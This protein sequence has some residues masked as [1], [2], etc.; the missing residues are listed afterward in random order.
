MLK[1]FLKA[2][3]K[4]NGFNKI[5]SKLASNC[6]YSSGIDSEF[7]DDMMSCINT[8]FDEQ[9]FGYFCFYCQRNIIDSFNNELHCIALS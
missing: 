1:D 8:N 5:K 3:D 9:N 4:K 2:M 7:E 6:F